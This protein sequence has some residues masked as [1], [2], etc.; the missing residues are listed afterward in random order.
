MEPKQVNHSASCSCLAK[1]R[2]HVKHLL[3]FSILLFANF[4]SLHAQRIWEVRKGCIRSQGNL[5]GGYLFAQKKISGYLNGEME[6]FLDDRFAYT[7]AVCFSFLTIKKN[8]TGIK[9]N[10]AVFSGANYHFLKPSR[11]D[12]YVGLTPGIGLLRATYQ[13]GDALKST[14]YSVAPL[15]SAQVGCNFYVMSFLHFFVKAQFVTGQMF[16][17]LPS[18]QRID[19]MKFMGGMGWNLRIWKPK[20]TDVWKSKEKK[21]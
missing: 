11:W 4:H 12:P 9:V 5:G 17:T 19:E 3:F 15:L 2:L 10:H 1:N 14:S 7:G 20:V 8:E 6:V 18:P 13:Q 21:S 16:G